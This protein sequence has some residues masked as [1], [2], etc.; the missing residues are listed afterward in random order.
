MAASYGKTASYGKVTRYT[1]AVSKSEERHD[2][3]CGEYSTSFLL[4]TDNRCESSLLS[5]PMKSKCFSLFMYNSTG[6][7]LNAYVEPSPNKKICWTFFLK[8]LVGIILKLG[9]VSTVTMPGTAELSTHCHILA[10]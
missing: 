10:M 8:H 7:R 4:N 2:D 9:T 6:S 5:T 1:E 3:S